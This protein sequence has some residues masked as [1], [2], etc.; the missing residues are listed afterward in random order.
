LLRELT[1]ADSAAFFWL[2]ESGSIANFYAEHLAVPADDETPLIDGAAEASTET[3][4]KRL[5][6]AVF[7]SSIDLEAAGAGWYGETLRRSRASYIL[8]GV[9]RRDNAVLGRVTSIPRW[10]SPR[11]RVARDRRAVRRDPV[12]VAGIAQFPD[13][14]R[15]PDG[16]HEDVLEDEFIVADRGGQVVH[17]TERG[18]RLLLFATGC[19]LTPKNIAVAGQESR[20][21]C[22]RSALC[23]RGKAGPST[24]RLRARLLGRFVLRAYVIDDDE[25]AGG[26]LVGV[27]VRRTQP[28]SL[29]LVRAMDGLPLSP[30]QREIALMIARGSSNRDMAEPPLVS[31]NTVAYHV[32]QLFYK[33]RVHDRAGLLA[34]INAA[35]APALISVPR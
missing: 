14:G 28:A 25:R 11:I 9:A 8:H 18:R 26:M 7:A 5:P 13:G 17:S 34:R 23:A 20:R 35:R 10:D 33:L 16:E 24:A 15:M 4:F 19:A 32:K 29:R 22:V 2:D 27:N 1:E 21:C 30:Q 31:M 12:P 3:P 6:A